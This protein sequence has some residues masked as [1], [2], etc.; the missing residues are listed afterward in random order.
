[1]LFRSPNCVDEY[2][3]SDVS[4]ALAYLHKAEFEGFKKGE[5]G[6]LADEKPWKDLTPEEY[7]L[8]K[9]QNPKF[10]SEAFAYR[11][12]SI[13]PTELIKKQQDRIR[14]DT[15]IS[16]NIRN[17][18]F[19]EKDDGSVKWKFEEHIKPIIEYPY[20]GQ[21]KRGCVQM[22]EDRIAE[23]P[24]KFVYFAGVDPVATVKS[25]TSDSLFAIYIV[26]GMIES[27]KRNENGII[28]VTYD[29]MKPV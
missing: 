21:D 13:Y 15:Q 4:K 12:E 19:Y 17:I 5:Y 9:S 16:K 10:M 25:T 28:E 3:N 18:S 6:K 1:M 27:K 8:L 20:R 14:L 22:V 7:R 23:N 24:D 2:G 11:K 26:K 29:G